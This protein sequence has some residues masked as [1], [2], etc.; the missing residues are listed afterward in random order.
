MIALGEFPAPGY[1]P[2][3]LGE[4][5]Q[6]DSGLDVRHTVVVAGF[7][8]MLDHRLLARVALR[9]AHV[10]AVFPQAAQPCGR[11]TVWSHYHASL[12]S[13]E[14]LPGVEGEG[15]DV[16]PRANGAAAVLRAD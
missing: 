2:W 10:H 11:L 4:L 14:Q 8:I 13:G 12:T 15:S 3:Q 7:K 9:R 6:A 1:Q 5:D 16:R